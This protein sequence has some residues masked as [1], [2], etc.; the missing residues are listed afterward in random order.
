M[1]NVL[2]NMLVLGQLL[3]LI[4]DIGNS[5]VF[6]IQNIQNHMGIKLDLNS[7]LD[8]EVHVQSYFITWPIQL[9][10]NTL[11]T[12]FDCFQALSFGY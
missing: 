8:E 6:K 11:Y 3:L 4:F 5:C 9:P 2:F 12:F 1:F 10:K 7:N